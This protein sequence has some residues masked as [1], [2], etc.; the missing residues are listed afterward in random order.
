M[1]KFRHLALLEE[2]RRNRGLVFGTRPRCVTQQDA[3]IEEMTN[4]VPEL[5]AESMVLHHCIQGLDHGCKCIETNCTLALE[6]D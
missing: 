2:K 3:T 4:V 5:T 1:A 6:K